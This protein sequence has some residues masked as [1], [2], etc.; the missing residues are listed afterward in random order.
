MIEIT[1]TGSGGRE[2]LNRRIYGRITLYNEFFYFDIGA[3]AVTNGCNIL[4]TTCTRI[5]NRVTL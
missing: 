2:K 5:P 1:L 4:Y 3:A